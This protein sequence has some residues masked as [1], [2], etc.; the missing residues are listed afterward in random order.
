MSSIPDAAARASLKS[1]LDKR[2]TFKAGVQGIHVAC[3]AAATGP[4]EGANALPQLFPLVARS[5]AVLR[6]RH[7]NVDLWRAGQGLF[8]ACLKMPFAPAQL[9]DLRKWAAE[10]NAFLGDPGEAESAGTA[11]AQAAGAAAMARE[12]GA[13]AA[14]TAAATAVAAAPDVELPPGLVAEQAR[15]FELLG[16]RPP[17]QAPSHYDDAGFIIDERSERWRRAQRRGDAAVDGEGSGAADAARDGGRSTNDAPAF[18]ELH[19][20]I[21]ESMEAVSSGMAAVNRSTEAME[22][23]LESALGLLAE[24]GGGQHQQQKPPAS[25]RVVAGL[26][27]VEAT[28]E[29]LAEWGANAS[30]AVCTCELVLGDQVQ[31]LPCRHMYHPACVA[32]WLAKNNSCPMCRH[33]L[34]TDDPHYEASKERAAEEETER[35]GAANALRGG[36]HMYI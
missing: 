10:A 26:P 20:Q 16:G 36:E 27:Q 17:G 30:C 13:S 4:D 12:V 6:A 31:A 8:T 3:L 15:L 29:K 34:P 32:P 5:A 28:A 24:A 19:R 11:P 2:A 7:T 18:A 9:A 33:E 1:Q 35:R 25:R 23:Q 14:A 22:Q 21:L